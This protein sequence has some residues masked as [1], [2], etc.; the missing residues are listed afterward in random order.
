MCSINKTS[1]HTNIAGIKLENCIYNASGPLCTMNY[2]LDDLF[3]SDSGAVLT[4]SSTL[5]FNKGND[6]PNYH[7]NS[8]GSI[9]SNG[10]CNRGIDYYIEY[11]KYSKK[12]IY[13]NKPYI[14][15]VC[16]LSVDD[17][18]SI[19]RKLN[20]N[21][22]CFDLVEL[23][24]SCPNINLKSQVG[25]DYSSMEDLLS[26]IS[27]IY[28]FSFGVKLPPYFDDMMYS[29][30]Y[31][32]ISGFPNI[33]F[34]T[35]IN[36]LGNGML[37]DHINETTVIKPKNGYGGIGG[38]YCKPIALSNVHKF[39]KLFNNKIDIV[40][41]GGITNSVDVFEMILA[42]ASAVQIGTHYYENGIK[43]FTNLTSGLKH[44]MSEKK[45]FNINDFKGSLKYI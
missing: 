12:N 40:G 41:C 8:Y 45:Y 13:K 17:N 30:V 32:V 43:N 18:L 33:K 19:F 23:N 16:G 1:L 29:S 25:Y 34:L 28:D 38:T 37:I 35:S 14:I 5:N 4:K 31:D 20:V 21:Q 11:G 26:S 15:S 24:L 39:Y 27:N 2:E 10:L 9:N 6:K 42:G 3:L 44:I 36:S 22:N 7:S